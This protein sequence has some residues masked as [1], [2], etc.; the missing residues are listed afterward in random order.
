MNQ[1]AHTPT[2][3]LQQCGPMAPFPQPEPD[4]QMPHRA[5]HIAEILI[6]SIIAL[7]TAAAQMLISGEAADVKQ[8][9]MSWLL[10]PMI[11]AG[12]AAIVA[13]L[14]N[15]AT[16]DRKSVGGRIVGALFFGSVTPNILYY[17]SDT[18]QKASVIPAVPLT[19]GFLICSLI[20]MI[21]KPLF[22]S[23]YFRSK[24]ISESIWDQVESKAGL[25]SPKRD[26]IDKTDEER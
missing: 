2:L 19:L 1:S 3:R 17:C 18:M 21:I 25:S 14:L 24:K 7:V 26:K 15:P 12:F 5:I 22:R 10:L 13:F 9:E 4:S 20:F 16:E 23:G 8:Q 11:G 6:G